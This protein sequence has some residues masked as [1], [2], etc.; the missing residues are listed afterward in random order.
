MA[1]FFMSLSNHELASQIASLIN[2]YNNWLTAFS[3]HSL[4]LTPANYFVE[5]VGK[6]VV[7]CAAHIKEYDTLTKI[8]HICV[9][10]MYRK[11]GIAKKLTELAITN[12][13]TEYVY[14]TV[15]ED[16]IASLSLASSIGFVYVKK[17]WFRD[18][19]TLTLGRRRDHVG[20][21]S[22][23]TTEGV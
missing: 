22:R 1:Q 12:A 23:S 21:S 9:L 20:S 19:W 14:M 7:G 2:K 4:L 17:H 6:E 11:K 10:P 3:A 5:V 18:H 15:R 16:N 8:Q 13:D